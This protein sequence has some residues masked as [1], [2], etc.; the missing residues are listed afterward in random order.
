MLVLGSFY[1]DGVQQ[2]KVGDTI[3]RRQMVCSIPDLS[4]MQVKVNVGE[5]DAPKVRMGQQV[6]VRLE[7]LP[8][9][10]FVGDVVAISALATEGRWWESSAN[11]GRKNFDVTIELRKTDPRHVKPGMTADVEFICDV[12]PK[13]IYVPI[14]CV[15]EDGGNTYCYVKNGKSYERRLVKTGKQND[16]FIAVT[17]GLKPGE[18]V[19]LRDPT[20]EPEE[21]AEGTR[22]QE[23]QPAPVPEANGKK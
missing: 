13:A 21:Q 18:V 10:M 8:D 7:A 19:A 4:T 22:G 3:E 1:R 16:N 15:H 5:A 20:R 14:E 11:A 6:V 23:H 9:K 2:Y 12:V 17:K